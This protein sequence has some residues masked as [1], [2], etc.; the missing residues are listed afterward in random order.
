MT[1]TGTRYYPSRQSARQ[2]E[3]PDAPGAEAWLYEAGGRFLAYGWS[4][5]RKVNHDFHHAFRTGEDRDRFVTRFFEGVASALRRK[6][7]RRSGQ[8]ALRALPNPI[9][10]DPGEPAPVFVYSWGWEQTNVE[11]FQVVEVKGKRVVLREIGQEVVRQTGPMSDM[12]V[13]IRNAFRAGF[14]P[15][16]KVVKRCVPNGT[17]YVSFEHGI[18]LLDEGRPHYRS[19]YA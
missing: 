7:E 9:T 18:G 19:W 16:T 10:L 11:Y 13:P 1:L 12:V 14:P 15:V 8:A 2:V 6:E 3:A 17:P 5:P 4:T